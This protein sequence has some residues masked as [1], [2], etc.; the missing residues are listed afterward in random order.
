MRT[1]IL[2]ILFLLSNSFVMSQ[3]L[4]YIPGGL[5]FA[6]R[7]L[8]NNSLPIRTLGFE[9]AL[10]NPADYGSGF[11]INKMIY[12]SPVS[13][14]FGLSTIETE[15]FFVG[16][17]IELPA[18]ESTRMR[19]AFG[20]FSDQAI[21][22]V[23]YKDDHSNSMNLAFGLAFQFGLS[24]WGS[25]NLGLVDYWPIKGITGSTSLVSRIDYGIDI[26]I[27]EHLK[28]NFVY[29][30]VTSFSKGETTTSPASTLIIFPN[31]VMSSSW[32]VYHRMAGFQVSLLGK[33][34]SRP[35][36]ISDYAPLLYVG[37]SFWRKEAF[38]G[39]WFWDM[40]TVELFIGTEGKIV[41]G[42]NVLGATLQVGKNK[43]GTSYNLFWVTGL[44]FK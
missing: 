3:S 6:S 17:G 11:N 38:I 18:D 34:Y 7:I 19:V 1:P 8:G 15:E 13:N 40:G 29:R 5:D 39:K 33:L 31:E 2:P 14:Y 27:L 16:T 36:D 23:V 30:N 25:L 22:G 32:A 37:Y 28:I 41:F 21:E 20:Y 42:I 44:L 26:D 24:D 4:V 10:R 9:G 35:D 43:Y 12:N